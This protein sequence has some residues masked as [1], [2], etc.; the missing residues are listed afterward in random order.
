MRISKLVGG[1]LAVGLGLIAPASLAE[2]HTVSGSICQVVGLKE[3]GDTYNQFGYGRTTT[4]S[5]KNILCPLVVD[6]NPMGGNISSI[7][8][9]MYDRDPNSDIVCTLTVTDLAG[10]ALFTSTQ[11]SVGSSSSPQT[12]SWNVGVGSYG[13]IACSIPAQTASGISHFTSYIVQGG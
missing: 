7:L 13:V 4:M 12:L 5:A 1:C 8:A 10:N 6:H 3:F 2:S 11:N 9:T